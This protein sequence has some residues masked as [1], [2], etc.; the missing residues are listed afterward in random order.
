MYIAEQTCAG[1]AGHD[2]GGFALSFR[3]GLIV[4]SIHTKGAFFHYLLMFVDLA[5]AIRAGPGA[6]A[7][8]D[9]LVIVYQYDT[10]I[11]AFVTGA[12][13]TY[14]HTGRIFTMKTAFGK[15]NGFGIGKFAN[16]VS[17]YAIEKCPGRIGAIRVVIAHR[18]RRTGGVPFLTGSYACVT[19]NADVEIDN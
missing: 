17:L 10:V 16:L 9:T 11:L 4:N 7:A 6:V 14:R 19:T 5:H 12:G 15:M 3:Q 13:R 18:S 8:T 1:G 2:A